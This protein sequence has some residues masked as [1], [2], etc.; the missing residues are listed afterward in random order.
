MGFQEV[1][2][3]GG[4]VRL[5][6]W[7][8]EGREYV[9]GV[10]PAEGV[11][12]DRGTINKK[13]AR[14]PIFGSDRPDFCAA[15]VL[16]RETGEHVASWLG[17]QEPFDFARS[18][19]ALAL[20]YNNALMAVEING[21]GYA[22]LQILVRDLHYSNLYRSAHYG[23][24]RHDDKEIEFGWRT[25]DVLRPLLIARVHALRESG[26]MTRDP[27]LTK[28]LGT[29]QY[30]ENGKARAKGHDKDDL[31]LALAI[32]LQARHESLSGMLAP[33]P[34][35]RTPGPDDVSRAIIRA[36]RERTRRPHGYGLGLVD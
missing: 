24:V 25:N 1:Q 4:H 35:P 21:P 7:P 34:E 11:V 27:V 23:N 17:Y 32:G 19:M 15:V 18:L 22:V 13:I 12:R 14:D 20:V 26:W 36:R 31:V 6:D 28:Q 5:W 8:L 16:D 30:D 9:M 2:H 29:M 10:D 33:P 3:P